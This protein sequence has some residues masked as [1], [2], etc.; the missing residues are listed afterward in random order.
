MYNLDDTTGQWPEITAVEATLRSQNCLFPVNFYRAVWFWFMHLIRSH[1]QRVTCSF[2]TTGRKGHLVLFRT[3]K[4]WKKKRRRRF[5]SLGFQ[6]FPEAE[7]QRAVRISTQPRPAPGDIWE[8]GSFLCIPHQGL[9]RREI[10]LLEQEK[11]E[12]QRGKTR[13]CKMIRWTVRWAWCSSCTWC[14]ACWWIKTLREKAAF[15]RR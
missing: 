14:S 12:E 1:Q 6:R 9:L 4:R 10:I 7:C 3:D 2:S 5:P 13:F 8:T 15:L 11:W